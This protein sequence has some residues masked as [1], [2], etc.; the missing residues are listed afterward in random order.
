MKY[1]Q[2]KKAFTLTELLVVVIVIGVLS[3]VV[4]PKFSKVIETRKT[5]EA[6][7][8]LA[9]IRT[10]Q[11]KRCTLDKPYA[12]Y[13]TSLGDI[14]ASNSDSSKTETKNYSYQLEEQ[15]VSATRLEKDYTLKMPS[16]TD[17]RLCCE[18]SYCLSLNKDY[19]LCD[20]FQPETALC[21]ADLCEISRQCNPGATESKSCEC[22]TQTRSCSSGCQWGAWSGSCWNKSGG[23]TE[24]KN[25]Q[26]IQ[27][28]L[29]G[30]TTRVCQSTCD[31]LGSCPAWT[32]AGCSPCAAPSDEPTTKNCPSGYSGTQTRTWNSST[33]SWNDWQGEC[34]CTAPANE[35]TT[36]ACPDGYIGTQTRTWNTSTCSWNDWEGEC[37]MDCSAP[38]TEWDGTRCVCP[39]GTFYASSTNTCCS[40]TTPQTDNNCWKT[41]ISYEWTYYEMEHKENSYDVSGRCQELVSEYGLGLCTR[42]NLDSCSA[43][44]EGWRCLYCSGY[45][46]PNGGWVIS[47]PMQCKKTETKVPRW[48][49]G[50]TY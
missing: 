33:C 22:G 12:G 5:T 35:P 21:A 31:G 14:I 50:V 46:A 29:R 47:Q 17:G 6:E 45:T 19:P 43:Q 4:L 48:T 3:A 37:R 27:S 20:S 28:N 39:S 41:E 44:K 36:Q 26:E 42:E 30:T 16:Y 8:M 25:C 18:G 1:S 7:E 49:N 2:K 24:T 40:S 11:E 34:R 23:R 10:E 32:M 15:G 9:A 38:K 13:F